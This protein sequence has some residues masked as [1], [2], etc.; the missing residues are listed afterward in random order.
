[1]PVALDR[2]NRNAERL[3]N[4]RVVQSGKESQLDDATRTWLELFKSAKC[5]VQSHEVLIWRNADCRRVRQRNQHSFAGSLVRVPTSGV[6]D[7]DPTHFPGNGRE[8]ICAAL[9]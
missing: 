6:F 8:E 7:E 5:L 2:R 3:G 9:P 1:M 4:F